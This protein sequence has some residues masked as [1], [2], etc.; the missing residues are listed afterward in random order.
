MATGKQPSAEQV[1]N[2]TTVVSAAKAIG[3]AAGKIATLVGATPEPPSA[4]K[5]R[6][7]GKLPE[8]HKARLPRRQKKAQQKT[9]ASHEGR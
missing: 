9:R 2:E 7:Q 1:H 4:P 5:S 6:K 8:K 3:T